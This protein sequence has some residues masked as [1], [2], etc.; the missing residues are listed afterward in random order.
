MINLR[1]RIEQLAAEFLQLQ[2]LE[3]YYKKMWSYYRFVG[4][5]LEQFWKIMSIS[6]DK[7]YIPY[8]WE[9]SAPLV[10]S[11]PLYI[12]LNKIHFSMVSLYQLQDHQLTEIYACIF[13][14]V[15]S[16]K[17]KKK[18]EFYWVEC[19]GGRVHQGDRVLPFVQYLLVCP[20]REL[21]RCG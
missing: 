12:Q 16:C 2:T 4:S 11:G 13:E 15:C 1:W 10:N 17:S 20:F 6:P 3:T 5:S 9:N 7:V 14:A 19:C 18:I 8:I 21:G